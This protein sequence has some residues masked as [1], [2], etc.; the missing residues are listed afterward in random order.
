[1]GHHPVQ[2]GAPLNLGKPP[3]FEPTIVGNRIYGRGAADNKG[4]LMCHIT[5]VGRLLEKTPTL[6]LRIP[7]LIEGEEEMGSPS[8]PKFLQEYKD[9]LKEADFVMLS[10]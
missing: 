6:P 9:R 7:F 4:P 10:D 2:P 8:F 5:A 1:A 3:A